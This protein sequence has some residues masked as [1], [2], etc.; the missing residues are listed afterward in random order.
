[1]CTLCS[2]TVD[3]MVG[4]VI[5]RSYTDLMDEAMWTVKRKAVQGQRVTKKDRL[6]YLQQ[7]DQ[8]PGSLDQVRRLHRSQLDRADVLWRCDL[9]REL[10]LYEIEVSAFGACML[11]LPSLHASALMLKFDKNSFCLCVQIACW[12]R[13]WDVTEDG[14]KPLRML[15]VVSTRDAKLVEPYI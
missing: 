15:W 5:T 9:G 12:V 3:E 1:M 8:Y 4:S 11:T 10:E 7:K 13:D 6:N 14:R 2:M